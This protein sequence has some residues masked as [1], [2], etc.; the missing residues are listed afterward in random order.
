MI[1]F[2]SDDLD[3]SLMAMPGA[4]ER[5][6]FTPSKKGTFPYKCWEHGGAKFKGSI[7]VM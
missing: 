1:H 3:I 5:V 7:M 2:E 4:P 6:L